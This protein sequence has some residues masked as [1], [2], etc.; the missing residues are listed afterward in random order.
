MWREV[1]VS[2]VA[3]L[4][5]QSLPSGTGPDFEFRYVDLASAHE[6]KIDYRLTEVISYSGSPSRARRLVQLGDVLFGTVRPN[7]N[8]THRSTTNF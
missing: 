3:E 4:N 7:L 1:K 2:D 5:P 8:L 6:G